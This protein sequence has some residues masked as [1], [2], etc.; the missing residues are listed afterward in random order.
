MKALRKQRGGSFQS[1]PDIRDEDAHQAHVRLTLNM[2][3]VRHENAR[4]SS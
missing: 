3:I 4:L 1:T 2:A